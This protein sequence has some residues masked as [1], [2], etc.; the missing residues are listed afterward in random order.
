MVNYETVFIMKP[1]LTNEKIA[2]VL[3]KVNG[4][5]SSCNGTIILSDSWGKRRLAYPV[6]KNKE[7]NYYLLQFS[8]EGRVV[9][10]LENFFKNSDEVIKHIVIKIEKSSKKK[11]EPKIEEKKPEVKTG[12]TVISDVA[13]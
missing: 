10:I 11:I 6:K 8:S 3:E 13:V 4:I 5:I 1:T 9:S 7:G 12:D 2:E